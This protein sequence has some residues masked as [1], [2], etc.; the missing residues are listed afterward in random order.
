MDAEVGMR[1][2]F[3]C[4]LRWLMRDFAEGAEGLAGGMTGEGVSSRA[5]REFVTGGYDREA[6]G[7]AS[8]SSPL[9]VVSSVDSVPSTLTRRDNDV[10]DFLLFLVFVVGLAFFFFFLGFSVVGY[11][12]EV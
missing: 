11:D 10:G 12:A 6:E 1:E 7:V 2:A 9:P 3:I 4:A 8:C 5:R